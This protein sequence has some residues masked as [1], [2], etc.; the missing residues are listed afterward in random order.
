MLSQ[1]QTFIAYGL[2]GPV[3]S[4]SIPPFVFACAADFLLYV[5]EKGNW[6]SLIHAFLLWKALS[7]E[8]VELSRNDSI[9]NRAKFFYLYQRGILEN[10][11]L[12]PYEKEKEKKIIWA[13]ALLNTALVE[14]PEFQHM[15][16]KIQVEIQ[17]AHER[18]QM[19]KKNTQEIREKDLVLASL[20]FKADE[21]IVDTSTKELSPEK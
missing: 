16:E 10:T 4:Y 8:A 17:K 5:Y 14:F 1:F 7:P 15:K 13:N 9:L 21:E 12:T 20:K 3:W 11:N 6:D 18:Y 19:L 2:L